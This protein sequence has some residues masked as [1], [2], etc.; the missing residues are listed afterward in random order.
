LRYFVPQLRDA[1]FDGILHEDRLAET[2]ERE[3]QE[4]VRAHATP[5]ND[6]LRHCFH[7]VAAAISPNNPS[8]YALSLKPR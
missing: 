5:E 7:P 8:L 1:F 4:L 3:I 2:S 6:P